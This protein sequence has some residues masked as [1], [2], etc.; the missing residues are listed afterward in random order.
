MC[1]DDESSAPAAAS[2]EEQEAERAC[3]EIRDHLKRARKV[4]EQYRN[5]L[6]DVPAS[7]GPRDA[8]AKPRRDR[9]N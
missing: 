9:R 2:P 4:V 3:D 8:G 1:P 7:A 5:I 6:S